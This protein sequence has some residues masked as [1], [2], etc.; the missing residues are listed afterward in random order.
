M[1]CFLLVT[2]ESLWQENRR[3]GNTNDLVDKDPLRERCHEQGPGNA[4][5]GP[6]QYAKGP[7]QYDNGLYIRRFP[8]NCNQLRPPG[9]RY[10]MKNM[11]RLDHNGIK[12][13]L[14]KKHSNVPSSQ[15]GARPNPTGAPATPRTDCE[16]QQVN[17]HH[18]NNND[19]PKYGRETGDGGYGR[20]PIAQESTTLPNQLASQ[21]HKDSELSPQDSETPSSNVPCNTFGH[22]GPLRPLGKVEESHDEISDDSTTT[23]GSF[24]LHGDADS[25]RVHIRTK[26]DTVV[27]LVWRGWTVGNQM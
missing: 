20:A 18:G 25:P 3:M 4:R 13:Q 24:E 7:G 17:G 9:A 16:G 21:V 11:P 2:T 10:P 23:S 8:A 15:C 14:A 19:V 22:V 26:M 12:E 27:W 1:Q 6:Q 5:R